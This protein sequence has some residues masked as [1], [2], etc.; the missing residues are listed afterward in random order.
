M[1]DYTTITEAETDP[2]A[3]FTSDLLKALR[4]NPLAIRE[5]NGPKIQDAA[6]GTSV[7]SAGT[8]WVALRTRNILANEVGSYAILTQSSP[9]TT[10][11]SRNQTLAGSSLR[12]SGHAGSGSSTFNEVDGPVASGTW[13]VMGNGQSGTSAS[14]QRTT[15]FL[16]IA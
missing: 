13:R 3:P 14:L 16:R 10:E 6:L 9:T 15:L 11:Y 8:D 5:G 12:F 2:G 4:D 1:V 7:T